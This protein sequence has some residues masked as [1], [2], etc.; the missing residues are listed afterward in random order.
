MKGKVKKDNSSNSS[1]RAEASRSK[2]ATSINSKS[3]HLRG[4]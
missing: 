3:P 1:P 2:E 4:F